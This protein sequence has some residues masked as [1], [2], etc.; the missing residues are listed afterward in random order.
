MEATKTNSLIILFV[1]FSLT[2]VSVLAASLLMAYQRVPNQGNVKAVGVGVYWDETCVNNVTL[3]DWGFLEPGATAN[4]VVWVRNEGN[5]ALVLNMTV[6]NWSPSNA[7][8]FLDLTWDYNGQVLDVGQK[9]SVG[10]VLSISSNISGI[11]DFSFDI[12]IVGIEFS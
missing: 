8:N 12:V 11:D 9:I 3:I 4:H 6:E 7:S 1:V 5:T 10:L 2:V